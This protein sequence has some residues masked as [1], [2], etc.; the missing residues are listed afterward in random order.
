M[1]REQLWHRQEN[2]RLAHEELPKVKIEL[3]QAKAAN[4]RQQ[5]ELA[6]R[7]EVATLELKQT[8]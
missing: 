1:S 8:K 3:Q 7:R 6:K 2:E 4:K 5:K